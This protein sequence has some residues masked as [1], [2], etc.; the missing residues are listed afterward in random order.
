MSVPAA[1]LG[2]ILIW[3]TTP[4]AIQWSGADGNYLFGL[5]A[6]MAIGLV[7]TIGLVSIMGRAIPR[8][9]RAIWSYLIAGFGLFGAMTSTYW[10]AQHIPSGLL[11]VIF[12]L[13]PVFTTIMSTLWLHEKRLSAYRVIAI[14]ISLAGLAVIFLFDQTMS[15]IGIYGVVAVLFAVIIHSA[16]SVW[17]KRIDTTLSPMALNGGSLMVALPLFVTC[18]FLFG[19]GVPVDVSV[20][21]LWAIGYLGVVGSSIGFILYYYILHHLSV[22]VISL[23]TLMTPVAALWLGATFNHEVLGLNALIGTAFIMTGLVFF[24]INGI[25]RPNTKVARCES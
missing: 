5:T 18:W 22:T 20:Q 14:F 11:S 1:Y 8:H 7:V 16:T 25:W 19:N 24:Q 23:I 9:K 10:A 21:S 15:D 6:R 2:V 12:G 4:L 3:S 13:S 17:I